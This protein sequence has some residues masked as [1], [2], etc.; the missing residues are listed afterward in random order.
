MGE[1]PRRLGGAKGSGGGERESG[2]EVGEGGPPRWSR[3][4]GAATLTLT[5]THTHLRAAVHPHSQAL[6]R[7]RLRLTPG[8]NAA[9]KRAVCHA[10]TAGLGARA[11]GTS[12]GRTTV[13]PMSGMMPHLA[14]IRE[15]LHP[16][17]AM[18][19]S[20]AAAGEAAAEAEGGGGG[21]EGGEGHGGG[22]GGARRRPRGRWW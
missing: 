1:V 13:A 5:L 12:S 15:N 21:G 20:A 8:H 4:G 11:F 22:R 3:R 16:G 9:V 18:R 2:E 10:R 17:V 19:M 7:S 14:S 6:E